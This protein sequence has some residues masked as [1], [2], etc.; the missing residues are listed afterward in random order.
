LSLSGF[1]VK[2]E[3]ILRVAGML[4]VNPAVAPAGCSAITG[5]S[6]LSESEHDEV[7]SQGSVMYEVGSTRTAPPP[8]GSSKSCTVAG[9]IVL[10]LRRSEVGERIMPVVEKPSSVAKPAAAV[11]TAPCEVRHT[12]CASS[13]PCAKVQ[14]ATGVRCP[15]AGQLAEAGRGSRS[16]SMGSGTRPRAGSRSTCVFAGAMA[17]VVMIASSCCGKTRFT[18]ANGCA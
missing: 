10:A 15:H 14:A 3:G 17:K 2:T 18:A 11:F 5:V 1:V 13:F 4:V 9:V 7:T 12:P 16:R 6:A 8:L